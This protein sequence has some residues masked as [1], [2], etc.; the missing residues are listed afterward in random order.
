MFLVQLCIS[1]V[2]ASACH[3]VNAF[4]EADSCEGY[5]C[6]CLARFWIYDQYD[7][8]DLEGVVCNYAIVFVC[9]YYVEDEITIKGYGFTAEAN[10][11][12]T[13]GVDAL[14]V[15]PTD[16]ESDEDGYFTCTFD[17]PEDAT[18]D[19]YAVT[20]EDFYEFADS[21]DFILG[22]SITLTPDEGPTGIVVEVEGR[23]FT[24]DAT[25]SF[26]MDGKTVHVVEDDVVT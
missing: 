11:T 7:E 18:Y 22:A 16:V 13:F 24:K 4:S 20:A 23:G 8:T 12:F 21:A 25:I 15:S 3:V 5:L 10:F 17:V 9:G 6:T 26:T 19:T 1:S 14:A 2:G